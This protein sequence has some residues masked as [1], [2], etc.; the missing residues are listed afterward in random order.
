MPSD[1]RALRKKN[2]PFF[3]PAVFFLACGFGLAQGALAQETSCERGIW[4]EG[5]GKVQAVPD[6]AILTVGVEATAPTV[7]QAVDQANVAMSRVVNTLKRKG[8]AEKDIQTSQFGIAPQ[9]EN[10]QDRQILV[11]YQVTNMV[12]AKIRNLATLGQIIDATSTAAGDLARVQGLGFD[13]DNP[14]SYLGKAEDLAVSDARKK[15]E[16]L[17]KL[18]GVG[19]GEPIYIEEEGQ[20]PVYGA[21]SMSAEALAASSTPIL[22]GE[23]E[24]TVRVRM[25]FGF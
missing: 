1:P 19:L 23:M 14:A 10:R 20:T 25:G 24:V 18:S 16:N 15:A 22:P 21:R 5:E 17:A 13:L 2:K 12:K 9:Y 4:V 7:E 11:G 3:G 6:I 8:V